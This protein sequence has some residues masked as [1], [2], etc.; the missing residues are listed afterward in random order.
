MS[1]RDK[2]IRL[3][4]GAFALAAFG[5]TATGADLAPE[6]EAPVAGITARGVD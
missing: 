1:I 6:P 5:I 3:T 2:I 4:L